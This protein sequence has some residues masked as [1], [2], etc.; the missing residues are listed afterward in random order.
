VIVFSFLMIVEMNVS[1]IFLLSSWDYRIGLKFHL[2][3]SFWGEY[4]LRQ[5][6][7]WNDGYH[8]E[9]NCSSNM[10]SDIAIEELMRVLMRV[11]LIATMISKSF[12]CLQCLSCYSICQG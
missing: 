9:M 5:M 4:I 12:I 11:V 1:L 3:S 2:Y 10:L 6:N 8:L 7:Y